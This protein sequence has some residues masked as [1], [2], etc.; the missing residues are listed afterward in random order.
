MIGSISAGSPTGAFEL[1]TRIAT[2]R[3]WSVRQL[4]RPKGMSPGV[5]SAEAQAAEE[6]FRQCTDKSSA[7]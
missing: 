5:V 2:S 7:E 6:A 4:K 3:R 1:L